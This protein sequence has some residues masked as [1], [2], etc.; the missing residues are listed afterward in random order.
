RLWEVREQVTKALERARQQKVIGHS[1][2]ARVRLKAPQKLYGFLQGFGPELRELFI[3]SQVELGGDS[4][5]AELTVEVGR[6][7]GEKCQRCW[8]SDKS[9]G[10][11]REHPEICQR[12]FETIRGEG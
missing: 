1:L 8:V 11:N 9:V 4:D 3:V 5:S 10:T 7:E 2:D 6:A 12:C